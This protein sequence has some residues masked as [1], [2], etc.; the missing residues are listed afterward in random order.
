MTTRPVVTPG[1]PLARFALS[2]LPLLATRER[3]RVHGFLES[4]KGTLALWDFYACAVR[5]KPSAA[6]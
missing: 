5:R 2:R 3:K 4:L 1:S 6:I